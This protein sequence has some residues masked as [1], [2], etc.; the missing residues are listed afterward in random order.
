MICSSFFSF[1]LYTQ[2]IFA[3][4]PPAKMIL[5]KLINNTGRGAYTIEQIVE[6]QNGLD[7]VQV[8]ESWIVEND[9]ALRLTVRGEKNLKHA[10]SLQYIYQNGLRWSLEGQS[11]GS[12]RVQN[13]IH[14]DFLQK[15]F[16][17][18]NIDSFS[19]ALLQEKI[20]PQSY[21]NK[22]K[23]NLKKP[24]DYVYEPEEWIRLGRD[25]GVVDYVLGDPSMAQKIN[26]GIWIEQDQFLIR[27]LRLS[28]GVELKAESYREFQKSLFY[29]S[30]QTIKWNNNSVTIQLVNIKSLAT[31]PNSSLNPSSLTLVSQKEGLES[32]PMKDVIEEFY[33]KFR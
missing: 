4:I 21:F 29:P 7:P 2:N 12:S 27:K 16:H 14:H 10:F 30:K 6:F 28:S 32:L 15:Y 24:T 8:R 22:K 25:S 17:F 20:L 11:K 13:K 33:E 18:K 5:Q 9:R 3:Y 19:M 1:I 31:Q 23:S 26:P